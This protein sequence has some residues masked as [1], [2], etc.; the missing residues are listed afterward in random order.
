M[1]GRDQRKEIWQRAVLPALSVHW[2]VADWVMPGSGFG[3]M[4]VVRAPLVGLTVPTSMCVAA[5]PM[6]MLDWMT[7]HVYGA[8][9]PDMPTRRETRCPA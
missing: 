1:D 9:A 6:E 8:P 4:Y 5:P 7:L 3:A 2:T